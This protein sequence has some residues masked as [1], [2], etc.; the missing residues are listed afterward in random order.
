MGNTLRSS[1]A[2]A[3]TAFVSLFWAGALAGVSFL[4]TPVK[5]Q[6]T[7]LD[8]PVALEVGKVTFAAFT[9]CELGLAALLAISVLLSQAPKPVKACAV[10]AVG[11]VAMQALWLLP[12]LDGRID[13]LIAG[14][15][16]AP[17]PHHMLYAIAEGV[18]LLLLCAVAL[19]SLARLGLRSRAA[20]VS[21]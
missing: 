18:K 11:L 3:V 21:A 10:V 19:V 13:A 20:A 2:D 8:L 15:P 5:F 12:V 4:A 16:L 9:R 17:S 1:F 7:S 6:A 14:R